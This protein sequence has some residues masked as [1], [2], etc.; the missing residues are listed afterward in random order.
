MKL[1]KG[2]IL[3]LI[4]VLQILVL[5][6]HRENMARTRRILKDMQARQAGLK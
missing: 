1:A 3:A 6:E 2:V 4:V 5:M